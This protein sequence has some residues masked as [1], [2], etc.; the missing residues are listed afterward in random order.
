MTPFILY[1]SGIVLGWFGHKILS[2][3]DEISSS[4]WERGFEAGLDFCKERGYILARYDEIDEIMVEHGDD[5]AR[6]KRVV[7]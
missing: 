4:N 1:I 3:K 6:Y 5:V 2:K 7:Q